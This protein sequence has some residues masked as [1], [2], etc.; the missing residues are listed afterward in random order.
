[1]AWKL[2]WT[3]DDAGVADGLATLDGA[4]LVVQDPANATLAPTAGKIPK[5]MPSGQLAPGWIPPILHAATHKDGGTDEVATAT[6]AANEIPKADAGGKLDV[7]W[8][9]TDV[10]DGIPSLDGSKRAVA[11]GLVVD[12]IQVVGAQKAAIADPAGG[13]VIDLQA[14]AAVMAILARLRT[15]GL[16][17]T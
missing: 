12:S 10:A 11:A 14:R 2:L 15:H 1:M 5:A 9:P 4:A 16:S 8:L 3:E 13:G 6:P 7:G 17:A